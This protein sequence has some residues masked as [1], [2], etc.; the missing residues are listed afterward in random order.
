MIPD[1]DDGKNDQGNV[2]ILEALIE[3][4]SEYRVCLN[5]DSYE[6]YDRL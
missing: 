1:G 6:S 3:G 2:E 4:M 5:D